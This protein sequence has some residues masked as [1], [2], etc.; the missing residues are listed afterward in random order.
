MEEIEKQFGGN[1]ETKKVQKTL[2]KQQYKNFIGLSSES[3]DQI[4]DRLQKLISQ[5]EI[6]RESLS[7]EDINLNLKNYEAEVKSSSS[8]SNS[9]QNIA[10]MS[11]NNTDS[12]K[13]PVSVVAS[14]S[15]ASAKILI[16][17]LPNVDTFSNAVIYSFFDSQSNS[18]Q[19]DNDDLK[20]IDADDLEEIDL[21]WQMAMLT[22]ECYNCHK[23]GYF[24][25]E[26]RSPKDTRRNVTAEPQ[27]R[28]VPVETTTSNSLVSQ[29]N[30]VGSCNGY[31][32]VPPPYTGS[33]MPPKPDLVSDP[34]DDSEAE[35]QQ[36]ALSFVQPTEQV[37]PLRPSVK[38]VENSI[39]AANHKTTI[40][41]PKSHRNSKNRKACF[42]CKSLTYL[43]IDCD[44][45][46]K[47]MA[48]TPAR[49][50][51]HRG[52]HQAVNADVPISHVTRP[53]QAKTIVT[54]PHSPP[55]RHISHSPSPKAS[56]FPPKV[57]AVKVP[58]DNPQH[59]LKDKGVIDSGC[60]WHMIRNLSY[61]SDFEEINGG[62]VAFGGNPK[63]GKISGKG[64]IRTRKLD[65]NDVY[66][67]KELKSNLFTVLQMCDKK[68]NVLFTDTKCIVLS[69]KFKLFDE[70]QVLLRV[71]SE[72]NMYNVELKNIVSSGALTCL[73]AK[74]TFDESNLWHRR[75]RYINFK[76]MNKL[77]KGNLVRGLII[78]VFENNHTCVACKKGKQHR[79][80]CKTKPVSSVSQPLQRDAAFEVKEPEFEEMKP[81]SEIYV[82]PNSSAQS[83]KHDD[84]TKR[85]AKGKSPVESST[86][87]R[88]LSAEFEDFSDN[89]INK[90]NAA[91]S[92][93]LVV[94][95]I[96]TN[97]TNTFSAAGPFNTTAD[98]TNLETTITVS[99]ILTIRVHKDHP[100]TQIIGD[101]S[102]AT[103][104]RSMTRV[105]KDQGGLSQINN[106]DFHTCM[107]ACFLSQEEPKRVH[108]ALKDP[109]WIEAMQEELLQFKMQKVWVLVD[110]PNG[111][112]A[113][114]NTQEEGIDYEE[115]FA[116]VARIEAIRL[117][118]AY[119]S[120][121]G[122]MVYQLDD[123]DYPDKVY[124][125]VMAQYGL[126]QAPRAWYE[127]LANY[128]LENGFQRG[129]IDQT[130]FIKRQRDGK[131]AST[132]IGAE[133]SLLKDPDLAYSNSDYAGA[134]LD[135]KSTTRGCQFL[136]CRLISWQCKKQI[137]VV[138]SS[139]EAEVGKGF[140][141]VDTPLFKG[142]IMAQQDDAV[143]DEGAASVVV[144]DV[145][146]AADEP[147][148]S[149][150]SP[151]TQPPP[152]SQDL[153][154]ALQEVVVKKDAEIEE[155][156][157]VQGR[158][159]ESQAQIYQIDLE[160]ADK[161]LNIQDDNATITVATTPIPTATIT[162]APSAAR[163]RKGVVIRDPEETAT[164][165]II[166]QSEPKSKDKGKGI[167]V[168][169]PK[170]LKKQAQIE[171]DE[172]YGREYQALKRKPQ[173]KAQ[174]RKNMMIYLR[175]MAGFKMDYFKG[176]SYDD[177]RLIFEKKFKS[178]MAFLVKNE[179]Q[180]E[181]ED[182][183]ALKRTSERA[184]KATKKKKL[185]EEVPVVDYEI[186]TENNKPYYK[187][188]RADR[189]PQLFLGFITLLRN[190]DREDLEM[191][192]S[193]KRR[194]PLTR[195]T[196]DQMLNNVI[197]EVEEE[198]QVVTAIQIVKTV[199]IKVSTVMYKLRLSSTAASATITAA[200]TLIAAATIIGAPSAARRRKLVNE[201]YAR[202]LEAE[203]NKNIYWD[204]VIEQ[205]QRKEKEDNDVMRFKMDII[206]GMSY[207]DIHPIFEKKFNSNM[208]FLVKTKEQMED[209]DSKA[210]KRT[211]ESQAEKVTKKQKLDEDVKE[212][213]KHL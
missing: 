15:A 89:N 10:F 198:I 179:E 174:A 48:Q 148:I 98:F 178:N 64:K 83:K 81:H 3:L 77:V 124:K 170:P 149:S 183:K 211:C 158:Q 87:Y 112:R 153:P 139:T 166:M 88:N 140:S 41:K 1:K 43:T 44:Y 34:E 114:G 54:K 56:N 141:R 111:K 186:Y 156:V 177:I 47:K 154:F 26:C 118:L 17:A 165:S 209:E 82:S 32:V 151:T 142:M 60:S 28:N 168:E 213:K 39:L 206:K 129:K 138:T 128:L 199:S 66:F 132:P 143:A 176:M 194:Y 164:P 42:V 136:G 212:L 5:L 37:K 80:S 50:H 108:Q 210:L 63:G 11:S 59:D 130:L 191:I 121:M 208:A 71:P 119:A 169:V 31:H 145:P 79:A 152:P 29:C 35:I 184:E 110:L 202:E 13:E 75:L 22:V 33:F 93:V 86:R 91:D 105:S 6:L 207:D 157:D 2:L 8:A 76:T 181:E 144:D 85:E 125:V 193:V 19:L 30:G 52:N 24:A 9:T 4:H 40:P 131:L 190:F 73:F 23:K 109:S 16:S 167:M 197:L 102:L 68:N 58:H 187:I 113:I 116:P 36:N 150:P 115:V 95:Q 171:H 38:H 203:L 51:A 27:R 201:A 20:Q 134:S 196:L 137:V 53:R 120:F 135:R 100:V 175:N 159:A 163:R 155:N 97:S 127:T 123:P 189:S 104:T 45:Y 117:F 69:V 185:D 92:T 101:L 72:N 99:H 147:S 25:R 146:T 65:F 133:K 160:H 57:T 180:M 103:Q 70:N 96:T 61:L 18:P 204:E 106:D 62:F 161:V 84:M 122:F 46:E 205:V 7:Q 107:F 200:T 14:V 67:V 49:N 21:K 12:T 94:G 188:I 55:R 173:T 162:A 195:F 172:A 126:H 182:S 192:L 78:K 74:A 90:V